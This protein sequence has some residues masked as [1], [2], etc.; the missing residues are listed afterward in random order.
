MGD[1]GVDFLGWKK[2]RKKVNL[3]ENLCETLAARVE[4]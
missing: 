1:C 4:N 2:G 3:E